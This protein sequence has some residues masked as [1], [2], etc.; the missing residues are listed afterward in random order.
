MGDVTS[1]DTV[2]DINSVCTKNH[3]I[4]P[5]IT[6]VIVKFLA[7]AFDANTPNTWR[8]GNKIH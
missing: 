7:V 1:S 6:A 3:C 2:D 5:F 8:V 4:S